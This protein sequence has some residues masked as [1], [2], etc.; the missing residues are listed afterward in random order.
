LAAFSL[1]KLKML[2]PMG[3]ITSPNKKPHG[4]RGSI[5]SKIT[6][7]IAVSGKAK[8]MPGTPHNALP[9]NTAIIETSAFIFTLDATIWV[10]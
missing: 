4:L 2:F 6:F 10:L 5:R 8:N 7:T 9:V 1:R 3:G